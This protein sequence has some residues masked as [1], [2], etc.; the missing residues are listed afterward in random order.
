MRILGIDPGTL[1][2]G[3]GVIDSQSN[4]LS[5][6]SCGILSASK[7]SPLPQRLSEIYTQL[8]KIIER[9]NPSILAIENPFISK[10]PKTALAIGQ[11]QGAAFIAAAQNKLE[12]FSYSPRLIKQT[13]T[14]FGG[15]SKEQVQEMVKMFL[16]MDFLPEP[17]DVADSLAVAICHTRFVQEQDI[18]SKAQEVI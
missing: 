4:E 15:A 8:Q 11:A 7:N 1:K 2:M 14:N 3:Y 10:N 13:V 16:E 6:V 18:I 5:L 9:W 12:I 17:S